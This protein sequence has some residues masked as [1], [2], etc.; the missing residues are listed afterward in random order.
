MTFL[1]G[2]ACLVSLYGIFIS[3]VFEVVI[4]SYLIWLW[5]YAPLGKLTVQSK[6]KKICKQFSPICWYKYIILKMHIKMLK[7]ISPKKLKQ[8]KK[9]Q[10]F[11]TIESPGWRSAECE[12]VGGQWCFCMYIQARAWAQ[13]SLTKGA[14][15]IKCLVLIYRNLSL[16]TEA[17]LLSYVNSS[18]SVSLPRVHFRFSLCVSTP[19]GC[20]W[21]QPQLSPRCP[22]PPRL[23]QAVPPLLAWHQLGKL[24]T[25][26][27]PWALE[28]SLNWKWAAAVLVGRLPPSR[29]KAGVLV[30]RKAS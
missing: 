27:L 24:G 1:K 8:I 14:F 5:V 9:P 12:G 23:W 22:L 2:S 13:S 30:S 28:V 26:P 29:T 6:P 17:F 10:D 21:L 15:K 4:Y 7:Y 3:K 11:K 25:N 20:Q 19:C 18:L 16:K